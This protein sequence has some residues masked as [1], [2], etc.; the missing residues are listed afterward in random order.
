MALSLVYSAIRSSLV[1]RGGGGVGTSGSF[2][3]TTN[4]RRVGT[5]EATTGGVAT[6]IFV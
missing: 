6:F 3:M 5:G 2:G 1:M 4:G